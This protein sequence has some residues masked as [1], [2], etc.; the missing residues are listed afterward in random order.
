MNYQNTKKILIDKRKLDTLIRLGC[1]EMIIWNLIK[2]GSFEKTGDSLIDDNLES[3]LD[4]KDF[5]NWGGNHNPSGVN[6]YTKR[7]QVDQTLDHGQDIGQDGDRDKDYDRDYYLREKKLQKKIYPSGKHIFSPI[8]PDFN[9]SLQTVK[10]L[11]ERMLDPKLCLDFFIREC[12]ANDY[13]FANY[14]AKM[15][16]FQ[17]PDSCKAYNPRL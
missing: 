14:D 16:N 7:G 4:I 10:V 3:L 17:Y 13:R 1:D 2:T 15:A 12:L 9:P 5:K 8:R 6:Q 11:Q